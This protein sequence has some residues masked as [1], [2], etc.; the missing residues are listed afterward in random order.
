M[1]S[2]HV[3]R[4]PHTHRDGIFLCILPHLNISDFSWWLKVFCLLRYCIRDLLRRLRSVEKKVTIFS[5]MNQMIWMQ[6]K[7]PA[8]WW[9]EPQATCYL[10]TCHKSHTHQL[11]WNFSQEPHTNGDQNFPHITV[12]KYFTLICALWGLPISLNQTTLSCSVKYYLDVTEPFLCFFS[13][14]GGLSI[15]LTYSD[16][17]SSMFLLDLHGKNLKHCNLM[18]SIIAEVSLG[19]PL[20]DTLYVNIIFSSNNLTPDNLAAI[21]MRLQLC[22]YNYIISYGVI[23]LPTST[24]SATC[25]IIRHYSIEISVEFFFLRCDTDDLVGLHSS[26]AWLWLQPTVYRIRFWLLVS[27]CHR[28]VNSQC[29]CW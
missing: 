24:F 20:P 16:H 19:C 1:L 13:L 11:G 23:K 6:K 4:E 15:I 2:R 12:K 14:L 18:Y 26:P 29:L 28:W 10:V 27:L 5:A 3:S 17:S 8:Q 9:L 22:W 25:H 7:I 21:F